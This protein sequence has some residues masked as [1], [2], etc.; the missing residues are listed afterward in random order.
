[1]DERGRLGGGRMKG[2]E[3]KVEGRKGLGIYEN[4]EKMEGEGMM[5]DRMKWKGMKER[6]GKERK[7]H[8]I[9]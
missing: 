8:S 6:R 3:I 1:M 4:K 5:E 9:Q 2:E 7:W